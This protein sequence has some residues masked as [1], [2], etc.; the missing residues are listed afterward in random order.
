MLALAGIDARARLIAALCE[1]DVNHVLPKRGALSLPRGGMPV[2]GSLE[3]PDEHDLFAAVHLLL[4]GPECPGVAPYL[5]AGAPVHE[6]TV[7]G[8]A[9]RD[10]ALA[11]IVAFC[12]GMDLGGEK[13]RRIE[14][15]SEELLMN[16]LYDAPRNS[17][18][19]PRNTHLD[20]RLSVTLRPEES[21]KLRFGC[22]GQTLAVAVA[23]PFGSLTKAAVTERLRKVADGVPRP[24]PGVAGAGLGLVLTYS[25]ANQL[26]F[27]VVPGRLTEVTAVVHIAGTNR[28]SQER[29]TAVH[30]YKTPTGEREG[31]SP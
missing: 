8:T 15:A 27:S 22:D 5:L 24:L 3:G 13:L 25:V 18:G 30:F 1:A 4:E 31:W 9:D 12:E 29:G 26:I 19:E 6:V 20:R 21:I 17:G 2:L 11:R 14:L 23:D 7:H 16:A 10:G 28:A